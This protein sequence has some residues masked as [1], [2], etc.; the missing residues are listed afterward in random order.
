MLKNIHG[1]PCSVS[2]LCQASWS[3]NG[4]AQCRWGDSLAIPAKLRVSSPSV[5]F[6]RIEGTELCRFQSG[7]RTRLVEDAGK[8]EVPARVNRKGTGPQGKGQKLGLRAPAWYPGELW[9]S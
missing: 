1:V 8:A 9:S 3:W 6:F 2:G 4:G 7:D 5:K